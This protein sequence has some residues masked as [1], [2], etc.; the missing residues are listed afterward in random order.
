EA[1]IE[2]V[3]AA[4]ARVRPHALA[5]AVLRVQD[6][7]LVAAGLVAK[8]LVVALPGRRGLEHAHRLIGDRGEDAD[9]IALVLRHVIDPD[10]IEHEPTAIVR[11]GRA[12]SPAQHAPARKR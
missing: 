1:V 2:A 9:L 10:P 6:A 12:A 3:L 11:G 7:D 8:Q 5:V 4:L